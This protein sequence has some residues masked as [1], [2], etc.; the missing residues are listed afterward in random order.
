MS[1]RDIACSAFWSLRHP[2]NQLMVAIRGEPFS[3]K[4]L[5]AFAEALPRDVLACLAQDER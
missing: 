1:A 4:D 2:L 3:L 5:I